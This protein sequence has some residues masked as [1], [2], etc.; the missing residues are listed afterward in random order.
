M[1]VD[2]FDREQAAVYRIRG[3][4]GTLQRYRNTSIALH[5]R[6]VKA[7]YEL[8]GELDAEINIIAEEY[9]DSPE[10]R[11]WVN[12]F[13]EYL[14]QYELITVKQG[15]THDGEESGIGRAIQPDIGQNRTK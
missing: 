15:D 1:A 11:R 2:Y 14:S 12:K 8:A 13:T 3:Y 4:L 5:G 6:P 10:V 7:L 9:W